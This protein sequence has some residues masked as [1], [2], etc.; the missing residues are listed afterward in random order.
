MKK[1]LFN[2]VDLRVLLLSTFLC[3]PFSMKA[4]VTFVHKYVNVIVGESFIIYPKSDSNI[5]SEYKCY[6]TFIQQYE[7]AFFTISEYTRTKVDR[8]P[9][10]NNMYIEGYYC[11]YQVTAQKTGESEIVMGVSTYKKGNDGLYP[12]SCYVKYHVTVSEKPKVVSISI[13]NT[14][15]L[16]V[17]SS[18]TFTPIIYENGASTSLSWSTSNSSVVSV[19]KNGKIKALAPGTATITCTAT[20]GVSAQCLVTVSPIYVTSI[21]LNKSEVNIKEGDNITLVATISPSNATNKDIEWSSTNNNVAIVGTTGTVVG[22]SEGTC[23]IKATTKDGSNKSASCLVHVEKKSIL[24]ESIVLLPTS[25]TLKV[26]ETTTLIATVSPQN[27]TNSS[28]TWSSSDESVA[29]VDNNGKVTAVSAGEVEITAIANDGSGIKGTC[30][31]IV[32]PI[33]VESIVLNQTNAEI[34]VGTSMTLVASVSPI[35]ATNKNLSW[36]SSDSSLAKVDET[37]MVTALSKGKV[38]ITVTANDGSLTSASCVLTIISDEYE[39]DLVFDYNYDTKEAT[40]ISSPNQYSGDIII[41]SNVKHEG[42]NFLVTAL[43]D[44]CFY[45]CSGLTSIEIPSSVTS[46]GEGAFSDCNGL[47]Y[48]EI[49]SSV[50]RIERWTFRD[51]SNLTS[52]EIP[53]SVTSIGGAAFAR[54]KKLTSIIIPNSVLLLLKIM[55]FLLQA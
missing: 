16:K 17:G 27:A 7:T 45:Q 36:S 53:N 4:D 28:L 29:T 6:S 50:T 26:G 3:L 52:I 22:I 38:T 35:N 31:I 32:S 40:L 23:Y 19:T 1:N 8:V 37:G 55:L 51:C 20:N 34:T 13:P 47:T 48:I 54:C 43:G 24:V 21:S 10:Y 49:P 44:D 33:L 9:W 46:I 2:N 39:G 25:N 41:P 18:Y 5:S 42:M 15:S 14:L 11:S 12:Q 30:C